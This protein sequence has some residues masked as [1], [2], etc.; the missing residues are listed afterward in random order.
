MSYA[1]VLFDMDGVVID[2]HAAVTT[3]WELIAARYQ[4]EL[5]QEIFDTAIYGRPC[6]ATLDAVFPHVTPDERAAVFAEEQD[7]ETSLTYT[8]MPG[9]IDLLGA[10][11]QG[12]IP[13]ALVTSGEQWK[14]DE[15]MR[16]IG[17][18]DLFTAYVT[19]EDIPQG[20]PHPACYVLGAQRLHMPAERC[21]TFED[22]I[23]GVQAAVA[24]GTHCIGVRPARTAPALLA[25]GA[26]CVIPDFIAVRLEHGEGLALHIAQ[27]TTLRLNGL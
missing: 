16:Q 7:F 2:T 8:A 22:S 27:D 13:T 25:Q 19:A 3:F 6:G 4:V 17:V 24:A 5:T 20:K 18:R 23:S 15:V 1:A 12:G 26:R 9:V 14:V 21:I 10:L 11:R